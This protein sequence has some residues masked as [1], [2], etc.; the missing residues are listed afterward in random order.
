MQEA[1]AE[2]FDSIFEVADNENFDPNVSK[3]LA[4]GG[5]IERRPCMSIGRTKSFS[6]TFALFY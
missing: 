2:K 4:K 6:K 5:E 1:A 3:M